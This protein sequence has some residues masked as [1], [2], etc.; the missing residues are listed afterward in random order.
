[1]IRNH[2]DGYVSKSLHQGDYFGESDCLKVLGYTF[3]GEIV[4]DSDDVE[5][6]FIPAG[7][8]WKIPLFEQLTMKEVASSRRDILML[9]FEYSRKYKIDIQEYSS[10]YC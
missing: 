1:M 6:W 9:S 5:C 10:Y 4:A 3:Y 2:D 7:D 8:F